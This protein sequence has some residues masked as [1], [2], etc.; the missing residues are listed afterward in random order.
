MIAA[1]K[2]GADKIRSELINPSADIR[3][4]RWWS[5]VIKHVSPLIFLFLIGWW[6]YRGI[7]DNPETWWKP[8]ST[9][10]TATIIFQWAILVTVLLLANKA[11]AKWVKR[12][13][14]EVD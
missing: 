1:R 9:F 8:F 5:F 14:E 2:Y 7:A 6:F 12:T 10:T 13:P 11:L 4:G 3:L